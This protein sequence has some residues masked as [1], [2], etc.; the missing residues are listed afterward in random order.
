L[1]KT[2]EFLEQPV[3]GFSAF[4]DIKA[5]PEDVALVLF[6]VER[7]PEWTPTMTSIRRLD[8]GPLAEGSKVRIRQPN[9]LPAVWQITELIAGCGFSWVTSSL[10]MQLEAGHWMDITDIGCRVTLSLRFSG[11]IGA[12]IAHLCGNLSQRY[13]AIESDCLRKRC[14]NC[15]SAAL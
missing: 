9:V 6:D 12:L 4:V 13:I 5:R 10:G 1:P 8:N 11:P 3:A 7:W 15:A 2:F 14:E